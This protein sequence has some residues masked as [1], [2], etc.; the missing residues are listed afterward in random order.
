MNKDQLEF[1]VDASCANAWLQASEQAS[2]RAS[3]QT[4]GKT[5][6]WKEAVKGK[7]SKS[8]PGH[9]P[10]Q[11][12]SLTRELPKENGLKTILARNHPN[13]D[14]WERITKRKRSKNAP[15]RKP[16]KKWSLRKELW[17]QNGPN[18][19][20]ATNHPK[21]D[22]WERSCKRNTAQTHPWPQTIQRAIF[23]N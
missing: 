10:S 11:K 22:F 15:D 13:C 4:I 6:V 21:A 9:K 3:K 7:R 16:Y 14:L 12:W 5:T 23:E 18:T 8:T 17:K 1:E 2:K 20:L 19:P